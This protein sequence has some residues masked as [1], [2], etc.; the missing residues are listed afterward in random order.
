MPVI[1][2]VL[3]YFVA[4]F[5]VSAVKIAL[6]TTLKITSW[7]FFLA[8]LY[9]AIDGISSAFTLIET[10]LSNIGTMG[11]SSGGIISGILSASGFYQGLSIGFPFVTSALTFVMGVYIHSLIMM[12]R[13]KLE[14]DVKDMLKL[15]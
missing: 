1:A 3:G 14:N 15:I 11:N 13:N 6:T 4:K 10:T 7:V 9:F 5:G 12:V 8:S 2:S